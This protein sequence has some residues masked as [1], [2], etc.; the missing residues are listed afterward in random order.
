MPT[1]E[2]AVVS[3]SPINLHAATDDSPQP[4]QLVGQLVDQPAV[5]RRRPSARQALRSRDDFVDFLRAETTGG[6][7]LIAAT[8]LALSW[9]NIAPG[10]YDAWWGADVG[11]GPHWLHLDHLR[12]STWVSDG[13]LAVFFYVAGLELKR[14]LVVGELAD[15][16]AATLPV[17]AALGGMVVPALVYLAVS[18][19]APGSG[20]GW[21][22]PVA[23][24]IAFALGVLS[25][26]GGRVP[27]SLRIMLLSLAVVDDL[28]GIL[29]IALLFTSG[30][31]LVWLA[32]AVVLFAVFA[33]GQRRRWTSPLLYV[34]LAVAAWV[35]VHASG[36]HATIAGVVLGLLVRA[37]PHDED[38][39]Q[40]SPVVRHEH[41]LHPAS[42]GIVVPVFALSATGVSVAPSALAQAWTEPINQGVM[43]GL[44]LGK[45]VG[46]LG[47]AWLAVRLGAAKLPE[48]VRWSA[49]VPIGLLAGIGY[50]VSLLIAGL[51]LPGHEY[52]ERASTA[53]LM[54]SVVAS[55][56]ALAALRRGLGDRTRGTGGQA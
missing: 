39:E 42:A 8:A 31:A 53:V 44:L 41:L 28:G 1:V 54:A 10:V 16:K 19:G 34:P 32:G 26:A 36:V 3:H 18:R 9:A 52:V 13:L 43:F 25:L 12:I 47:G 46:V 14:E 33:F 38:G 40:G 50:T 35:C 30:F 4:A 7:L 24:D 22:I 17:A 2:G 11:F 20:D 51:A 29:L 15:P 37:R 56:M 48:G 21:A 5:R 45:P 49:L 23:T 27:L 55:L 6:L